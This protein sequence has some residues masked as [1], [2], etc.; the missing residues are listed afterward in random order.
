MQRRF[1]QLPPAGPLRPGIEAAI[2]QQ[3]QQQPSQPTRVVVRGH[4]S[5][6]I[7]RGHPSGELTRGQTVPMYAHMYQ[8][9]SLQK[10]QRQ[11]SAQ[12]QQAEVRTCWLDSW[13]ACQRGQL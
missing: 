5:G 2:Q 6:E 12:K 8:E 13:F 1:D 9:D 7:S 3:Q 10:L 4:T 11:T